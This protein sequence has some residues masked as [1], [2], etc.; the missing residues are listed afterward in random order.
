MRAPRQWRSVELIVITALLRTH[1]ASQ[2]CVCRRVS[3]WPL[4]AFLVELEQGAGRQ[5]VQQLAWLGPPCAWRVSPGTYDRTNSVLVPTSRKVPPT[6]ASQ[7][8]HAYHAGTHFGLPTAPT[9]FVVG[10]CS[11]PSAS[12]C[13]TLRLPLPTEFRAPQTPVLRRG[14]RLW[15]RTTPPACS[16]CSWHRCIGRH[17][18]FL[19]E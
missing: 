8:Q 19:V 1:S 10:T 4:L 11:L 18:H 17:L 14:R 7:A 16:Y 9:A 2:T 3:W 5:D 13:Q 12:C 15:V 6:A